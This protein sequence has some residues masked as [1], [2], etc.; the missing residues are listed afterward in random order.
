MIFDDEPKVEGEAVENGEASESTPEAETS[1]ED[2]GAE[3]KEA[4]E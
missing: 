3:E 2:A 1:A 4:T